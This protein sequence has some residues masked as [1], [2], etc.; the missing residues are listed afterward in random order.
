MKFRFTLRELGLC[1][2]CIGFGG[3]LATC[4]TE[5]RLHDQMKAVEKKESELWHSIQ[6]QQAA[7][8]AY[9]SLAETKQQG[10]PVDSFTV[11]G[12]CVVTIDWEYRTVKVYSK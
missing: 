1:V 10:T 2:L 6:R 5:K 11:I 7:R 12:P 8:A 9:E 3:S 4:I